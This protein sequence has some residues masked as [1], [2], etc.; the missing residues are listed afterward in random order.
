MPSPF[1][2]MDPYLEHPEIWPGVHLLLISKLSEYLSPQLRPKYRVAVEVRIYETVD[3]QSL[4]VGVPDL[5]IKNSHIAAKQTMSN[6]ATAKTPIPI[7]VEVPVP[8]KIRQ[9]YLKIKE[10]STNEIVTIIEILSPV[11]KRLGEGR[12]QYENKRA[13]ILGS[14]TNLVEIDFLRKWQPMTVFC[15]H[16]ETHY[17]ILVS[18]SIRR[19]KADLF[20]FNLQEPIPAFRL[21]LKP[22]DKEPLVDLQSL[23]SQ[24]Y[25]QGSY[26][27][28]IDYTKEP[29]PKLSENDKIWFVSNV[30]NN[31]RSI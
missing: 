2:G 22:G 4:L 17:R 8:E 10:V 19:P 29:V 24:V 1:P 21:P 27:L 23:L 18:Q 14:S 16:V 28:E 30:Y 15:N 13:K 26:D 31:I 9:G 12:K 11:N 6:I 7:T 20:A 5:A 25:D 3:N